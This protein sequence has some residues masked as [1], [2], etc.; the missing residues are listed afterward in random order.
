MATIDERIQRSLES[1][2]VGQESEA[3]SDSYIGA[4]RVSAQSKAE[5]VLTAIKQAKPPLDKLRPIFLSI[6]G[7]DGEE[8]CALLEQSGAEQG[9][10]VEKV[11]EFADIARQRNSR[12]P[13]GKCIEIFEGDAQ[14]KLPEAI[15]FGR[16]KIKEGSGDFLAVSCHAVIHEL[17][18][19][20]D[21]HFDMASFIGS[22]FRHE[23]VA[24]WFTSREPGVPE[25]WPEEILLHAN[26]HSESLLKLAEAIVARHPT[27]AKLRP[28]PHIFGDNVRLHKTLAM[29]VIA[30]LFYIDDLKHEIN[31]RSTAMEHAKFQSMLMLAIGESSVKQQR[32]NATTVSAPTISFQKNWQEFQI[33]AKGFN[34][35]GA[36]FLLPV[37]ESQTRVIAWRL[38][39]NMVQPA[40]RPAVEQ[41]SPALDVRFNRDDLSVAAEAQAAQDTAVLEALCVSRGRRWIESSD[42]INAN[43]LLEQIG[44]S[45]PRSSLLGCWVHYLR[46]LASLFSDKANLEMFSEEVEKN[47]SSFGLARLFRAERMEFLR[48]IGGRK[49]STEIIEIANSLLPA[50]PEGVLASATDLERYVIATTKFVIA[51][52]LRAGGLYREAWEK[53]VEAEGIYKRNVESHATELAHCHYAKT[54]CV[55]LTG[56][57]NFDLQIAERSG[58]NREFAF[59]LIA[60]AYAHAAWI[61]GDVPGAAQHADRAATVFDEIDSPQYAKRARTLEWLL[62][63]WPGTAGFSAPPPK[64]SEELVACVEGLRKPKSDLS[65]LAAWLAEQRPSNALGLIQFAKDT[66]N[67]TAA[68]QISLPPT[69]SWD[70]L[71]QNRKLLWREQGKV[72]SLAEFDIVLRGYLAIPSSR[73]IPLVTD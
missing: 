11:K 1:L 73:R 57:A 13:Q 46:S 60:L 26:C 63:M 40:I 45:Y 18:D 33:E 58:T 32:A 71:E 51:N 41:G 69:L 24:I 30:K 19:R 66:E 55:A 21:E 52:L 59:A 4:F 3:P 72:A 7:G 56:T 20:S 27:F 47:A 70:H 17:H 15:E 16:R 36:I 8:L 31:E 61:V 48:K 25:K 34:D 54:V 2:N 49:H 23:E 29:E 64:G 43:R 38:P 68:V 44:K 14:H 62:K 37:P 10:L 5:A 39:A 6:G 28:K 22:I 50:L 67:W 35:S 9:I 42:R 12:L 53:I 65:Q